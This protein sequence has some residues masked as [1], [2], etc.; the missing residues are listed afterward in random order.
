MLKVNSIKKTYRDTNINAL[1]G[2][3]FS[4]E[5]GEIVGI[6]G[7][8]GSGKSTLLRILR[9]IEEFDEGTI[10][11]DGLEIKPDSPK[12]D[13]L[14]LQKKTAIQLQ[15][16]FGLWPDSPVEN[17]IRALVYCDRGEEVIPD[18]EGE[19]KEYRA[20]AVEILK[21]VGL[22][23]RAD[24]WTQVLAGGEKQRLIV[25]RQIARNPKLLLLDEPGTMTCPATRMDLINALKKANKETGIT[26][27]FASHNPQTHRDLTK[28]T[29]LLERGKIQAD[30]NTDDILQKFLSKIEA[31]LDK[32][33]VKG[34]TVLKMENVSKIYKMIT[35][36]KVFE[37]SETTVQFRRGEI[38][39]IVGPS[40]AGKT[41]ILRMLAGLELPDK[42]EVEVIYDNEWVRLGK[43]GRKSLRARTRIGMLHQEFDLPHW[44][45]VLDLFAAQIGIKDPKMIEDALA[46]A[47]A[48]GIKEEVVDALHR[49][50]ELPEGEMEA[51]L[52]DIGLNRETLH[53]LFKSKDPEEAKE[54]SI[55]ALRSMGLK[56]GILERHVYE[57]SGGEKIRVALA[58]AIIANPR[59]L[60]LD[61]PFG[62]LDPITL[63]IVA[64]SL[65][66][67]KEL[68]RPAIIL[69]SHQLDLV[70]EVS[71]RCIL[72]RNGRII[73]D[74]N[75]S[76]VI[77][78][79]MEEEQDEL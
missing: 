45:K 23:K 67:I 78:C 46:R 15:R 39:G 2:V 65:K 37:M 34:N 75:P 13:F 6:L 69:V 74:G 14:S 32:K 30:G 5:E 31:P 35:L 36:G 72:E 42:G 62:D 49:V 26:I 52:K 50:A 54:V 40:G 63:R 27:I 28:R 11:F 18:N 64:N 68:L 25:A 38:V 22:E 47:K 71:D 33:T 44:G 12:D 41:I 10:C 73:M 58:L 79:F 70:E 76:E 56:Q 1:D 20:R 55:A 60:I 4:V 53:E 51:R 59:V 29:L 8:S 9:G 16:T 61:E 66:R 43:L 24:M 3:S 48:T 77:K 21:I 17:V 57:L 19:Y 7:E